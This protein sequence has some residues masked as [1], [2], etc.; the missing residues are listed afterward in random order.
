MLIKR[1]FR[2]K[3]L[4]FFVAIFVCFHA[5]HIISYYSLL[6][7]AVFA[8]FR[9]TSLHMRRM[10]GAVFPEPLPQVA[11]HQ[12]ARRPHELLHQGIYHCLFRFYPSI[13]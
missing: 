8:Y 4:F 7:I 2:K 1:K 5:Y 9:R 11:H 3:F 12:Q 6:L 13:Q 10:R